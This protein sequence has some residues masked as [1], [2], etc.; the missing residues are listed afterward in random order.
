MALVLAH[1]EPPLPDVAP[2]IRPAL[3]GELAILA[4]QIVVVAEIFAGQPPQIVDRVLADRVFFVTE[5]F[6][7][8]FDAMPVARGVP[9]LAPLALVAAEILRRQRDQRSARV[10]AAAI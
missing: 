7:Q 1:D 3:R 6:D 4:R 5:A 9:P 10:L 2:P 8:P